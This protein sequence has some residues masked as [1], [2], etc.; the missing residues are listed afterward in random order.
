MQGTVADP[1]TVVPSG[2]VT[3]YQWFS[4]DENNATTGTP[5]DGQTT[6]GYKPETSVIGTTYYYCVVS[7]AC[8]SMASD[9]VAIEVNDGKETPCAAWTI[10]E[11]THGGQGFSFSVVAKKQGCSNLWDGT[12]TEGMLTASDGVVLGAVTVNNTTMTI[13]GTYGVTGS[14]ESPVTF[15]L[16]LPAT[17][18]QTAA[19]LSQ[20][21]T[22]TACAGG[23]EEFC[24]QSINCKHSS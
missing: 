22:F 7:N 11:P 12:L 24:I 23:A 8:G 4:N 6:G 19:T 1:L 14:A 3:G 20:T 17:A 21:R 15:Y 18:T 16:S 5:I 9:V 10:D 2:D 13:S